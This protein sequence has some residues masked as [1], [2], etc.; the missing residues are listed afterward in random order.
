MGMVRY[1]KGCL[2]V[3]PDVHHLEPSCRP[4]LRRH[5]S[6]PEVG[7]NHHQPDHHDQHKVVS[8]NLSLAVILIKTRHRWLSTYL[9]TL[10]WLAPL[11]CLI[12]S[13]FEAYGKVMS[14]VILMN[15]SFHKV[16]DY[17]GNFICHW[18]SC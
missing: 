13:F 8:E 16:T 5:A 6:H 4:L 17:S 9:V 12:P 1:Y 10:C 14:T 7:A 15:F 11:A 3:E 18:R 2:R